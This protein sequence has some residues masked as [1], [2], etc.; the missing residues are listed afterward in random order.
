MK[1]TKVLK[2]SEIVNNF[3]LPVHASLED[4]SVAVLLPAPR[5]KLKGRSR[6]KWPKNSTKRNMNMTRATGGFVSMRAVIEE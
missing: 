3:T 2:A 1:S 4:T 6:R 5:L